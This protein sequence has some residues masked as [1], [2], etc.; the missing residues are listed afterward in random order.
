MLAASVKAPGP[1][2]VRPPVPL[3][4]D[5]LAVM[6]PLAVSVSRLAPLVI[7]PVPRVRVFVSDTMVTAAAN[8]IGPFHALLLV[9]FKRAPAVPT[10]VPVPLKVNGSFVTVMPP[11]NC[12][13]APFET[14]VPPPEPPV[15]KAELLD[16]F[17][18][19][20]PTVVAPE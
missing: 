4:I 7:P 2:L 1:V 10:P 20:A 9:R 13:C 11:F 18:T 6:P 3:P 17:S 15:P 16:M 19:P 8:V 5:P 14:V 12:N